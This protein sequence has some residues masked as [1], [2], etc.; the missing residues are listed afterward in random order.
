VDIPYLP[1]NSPPVVHSV[2]VTSIVGTN[3]GKSGTPAAT[4]SSAYSITVTDTG[5]PPAATTTSS[6]SQS[7]SRLQSTQ[8]QISW[9]AD[10]PDSDKLVYSVYFRP[11]DGTAWQLIRSRMFEN[12]LLLDPDVFADG[13][14]YFKVLASDAPANAAP[15]ARQSELAS[16]PV[17]IDNT[18]PLVTVSTA[19]RSGAVVDVDLEGAD[20]TSPLRLCEYSMDAGSWQPVEATDGVTDSPRE[21]FHLHLDNVHPGEH[22]LVF[23]IYDAANNAGLARVLI[24]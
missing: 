3:P 14:Y 6:P 15:F 12:T 2:S 19:R 7:V 9:Q 4:A 1:Q 5:E 23:R 24:R 13:R 18:P 11:E 21:H 17:L 16:A 22:L 8:T 20:T 10:D